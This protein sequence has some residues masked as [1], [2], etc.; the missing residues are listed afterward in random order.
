MTQLDWISS[1]CGILVDCQSRHHGPTGRQ[2]GTIRPGNTVSE[3][4]DEDVIVALGRGMIRALSWSQWLL[5]AP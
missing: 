2:L 4:S 5:T 3:I 1:A